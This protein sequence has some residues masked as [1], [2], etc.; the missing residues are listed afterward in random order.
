MR[1]TILTIAT[2]LFVYVSAFSQSVTETRRIKTTALQVYENY[3]VVMSGLYSNSPYTEDNIF[4]YKVFPFSVSAC[5][6]IWEV[7]KN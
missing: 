1:K 3:K 7:H 6:R 5:T 4:C 2:I